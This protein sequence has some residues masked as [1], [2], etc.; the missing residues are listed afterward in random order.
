VDIL[1]RAERLTMHAVRIEDKP[2]YQW[3]G[4]MLDESRTFLGEY[5]VKRLLDWMAKHKLNVFHW[6]LTDNQG[7]RVQILKYPE[8][9]SIGSHRKGTQYLAWGKPDVIET[10][11]HAG[12]YT[13]DSIRSVVEYAAERNIM[14]V[15]EFGMPARFSAAIAAFPWLSCTDKKRDVPVRLKGEN[16]AP[17]A[18]A[19]KE[20]VYRFIYDVID[21][22]TAL[23]PA[24]YFHIGGDG[25]EPLPWDDCPRCRQTAEENRLRGREG[26]KGFF[27]DK[28]ALYLVDKGK[29]PIARNDILETAAHGKSFVIQYGTRGRDKQC[30]EHAAAGGAL[31]AA[32]HE[33]FSFDMPYASVNLRTTYQFEP[34]QYNLAPGEGGL[35]GVE[36][37]LWT[38]W[39]RT[40]E[41]ADYQLFPRLEALA[42]VAWSPK[43]QRDYDNF[44]KRLERYVPVLERA[45]V[46]SAPPRV[47]NCGKLKAY[48]A[49]RTFLKKNA[50]REYKRAI[51][52][53]KA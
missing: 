48:T 19:G 47:W 42:E 37:A 25:G 43:E 26:L 13:Q 45:K 1:E 35:M 33:A 32:K 9:T 34:E 30:E 52:K 15:P 11:V 8:L 21:E 28:I 38:E 10:T 24:P 49:T 50:H 23:F 3:R 27:Y 4:L 39:V 29:K 51:T 46:F 7:W 40:R 12:F 14:I 41:R 2:R 18:C 5:Y 36:A 53:S 20:E 31:I 6:H 17:F 22:L 16:D 44:L